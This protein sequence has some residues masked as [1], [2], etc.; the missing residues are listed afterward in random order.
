MSSLLIA[1]CGLDGSGKT[2]QI[3]M[4]NRWF[5]DNGERSLVT[6]QP[7]DY[8][9]HDPRVRAYLDHG[10]CPSME[11]IALLSAAD[12]QWHMASEI[13]PALSE[14]IHVISDRYIYSSYA[15]FKARGLDYSYLNHIYGSLR[16]PDLTIFLDLQPEA[17]LMR[18]MQR[19]GK[20]QLKYEE[21]G[22][23]V[24]EKVRAA[25][26]DVLPQDTLMIDAEQR[27]DAIHEQIV[28]R[29]KALQK[30]KVTA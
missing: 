20:E 10:I 4:L 19:D 5:Q 24:F 8:Y 29:V 21:Q 27:P 3:S 7:T 23:E 28:Q 16:T 18:V 12:R 17:T 25:F 2:T 11:T 30:R 6:K 22:T 1:L 13:E 15:F 9:R 26:I 14:G